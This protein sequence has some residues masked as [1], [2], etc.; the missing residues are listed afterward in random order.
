M[1]AQHGLAAGQNG[2]L[3]KAVLRLGKLKGGHGRGLR[4]TGNQRQE[5]LGAQRSVSGYSGLCS[6]L[7]SLSCGKIIAEY[8]GFL[9]ADI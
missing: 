4:C 7:V 3:G 9:K 2:E 8:R 6:A 1:L 5:L